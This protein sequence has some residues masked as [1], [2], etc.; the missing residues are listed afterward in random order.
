MVTDRS[1]KKPN[2][3]EAKISPF[4]SQVGAVVA[5]M[6]HAHEVRGSIPLP[7]TKDN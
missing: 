3:G 5:R 2:K 4:I 6:V 7:A 1:N